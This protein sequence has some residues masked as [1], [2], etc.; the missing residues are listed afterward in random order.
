MRAAAPWLQRRILAC[1][2]HLY[3]LP[4]PLRTAGV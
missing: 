3:R 2:A 1:A 4:L